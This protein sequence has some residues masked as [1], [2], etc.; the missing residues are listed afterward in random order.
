MPEFKK[1]IS[2][3]NGANQPQQTPITLPNSINGNWT[4]KIHT[5][6]K[7][8]KISLAF[9]ADGSSYLQIDTTA[10]LKILKVEYSNKRIFFDIPGD[11]HLSDLGAAPYDLGFELS[12]KEEQLYGA[13]TA[14][15]EAQLAIWVELKKNDYKYRWL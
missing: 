5:A 14:N 6:A 1:A 9:S 7:D 13:I 11:L 2:I 15:G 10:R 4:G 8:I 12:I 3:H